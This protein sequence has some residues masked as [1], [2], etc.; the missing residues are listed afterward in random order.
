M[1]ERSGSADSFDEFFGASKT[2]NNS[3]ENIKPKQND[4]SPTSA[5]AALIKSQPVLHH[6]QTPSEKNCKIFLF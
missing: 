3:D 4:I 1:P 6:R 2:D 5:I